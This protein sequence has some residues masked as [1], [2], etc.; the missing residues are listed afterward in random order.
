MITFWAKIK[1]LLHR[2]VC[3]KHL[4]CNLH[5]VYLFI[6]C[7][8]MVITDV[9]SFCYYAP[10]STEYQCFV[11]QALELEMIWNWLTTKEDANPGE[12]Q[13]QS[14]INGVYNNSSGDK[15]DHSNN[16]FRSLQMPSDDH[17]AIFMASFSPYLPL[18]FLLLSH[19][20]ILKHINIAV[21]LR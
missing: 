19:P 4:H 8:L 12:M 11:D 14:P 2:K 17:I 7:W 10:V 18:S 21:H 20:E 3:H 9:C 5:S 1:S 15:V 6:C 13:C 16:K